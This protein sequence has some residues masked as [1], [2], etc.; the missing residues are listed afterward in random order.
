MPPSRENRRPSPGDGRPG[1]PDA[2]AQVLPGDGYVFGSVMTTAARLAYGLG[3]LILFLEEHRIDVDPLLHAAE[4]PRFALE[5]PSSAIRL[6]QEIT[7]TRLALR[8]LGIPEAGLLVGRRYNAPMFG[9]LGLAASS[10]PTLL[11]M[12]RT[13]LGHPQLAWGMFETTL[14]REGDDAV[15]RAEPSVDTGD[16]TAFFMERDTA[17]AVTLF[18][19]A[20]DRSASPKLV[21]FR[22]APP[23]DTAPYREFF[24]CE[25]LFHQAVNESRYAAAAWSLR[26]R[27][28]NEMS[29]RFF[30]NQCRR[31]GE[32]LARPI[33]FADLTRSRLRSATPIPSLL[34]LAANLSLT[35]R[36]LQRKLRAEGSSF[37]SLLREV[38]LERSAELIERGGLRMEEIAWR[39]GFSD[40]VAF[41]RAF[42]QWT[43]AAPTHY[44][45]GRSASASA[46]IARRGRMPARRLP[47]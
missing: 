17:C 5:E 42:K 7:F 27:L 25:V 20:V 22:H 38:R 43:G 39:L 44:R 32:S 21:R 34:E 4:I 33:D 37:A 11:E 2:P 14:W 28:A 36:T 3:P 35:P 26:P 41:S 12:Q 10:A 13:L 31:L 24:G 23:R 46:T 16:C 29:W 6:D 18:R 1:S 45:E 15:L 47:R 8:R 30:E 40:A 9:L 19:D